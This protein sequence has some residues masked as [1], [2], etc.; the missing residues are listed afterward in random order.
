MPLTW[1]F[2]SRVESLLVREGARWR[3]LQEEELAPGLAFS[4][5]RAKPLKDGALELRCE[6]GEPELP[7]RPLKIHCAAPTLDASSPRHH[8]AGAL[9]W[10]RPLLELRGKG[11]PSPKELSWRPLKL[12]LSF[13]DGA[14]A[15][16]MEFVSSGGG[17][18]S[19]RG[20]WKEAEG[21]KILSLALSSKPFPDF[22]RIDVA[23]KPSGEGR[24]HLGYVDGSEWS[25][26]LEAPGSI[27]TLAPPEGD[28]EEAT[29][30]ARLVLEKALGLGEDALGGPC[31]VLKCYILSD[32][33][34]ASSPMSRS[35][36]GANERRPL[37][38][39]GLLESVCEPFG[40]PVEVKTVRK[41]KSRPAS[42][43]A[44]S[45][46]SQIDVVIPFA[47]NPSEAS[48]EELR[49]V[50]RSIERNFPALGQVWVATDAELTAF[51]GLSIVRHD[52]DPKAMKDANIVAKLRAVCENRALSESFI[53]WSDD[54]ILL[55]EISR[56]ELRPIHL[57]MID[58]RIAY[59]PQW[60]AMLEATNAFLASRGKIPLN[61]DSHAPQPMEKAKLLE[62]AA[63]VDFAAPPGLT[64]CSTYFGLLGFKEQDSL[65]SSLLRF[66][67][68]REAEGMDFEKALEGKLWLGYDEEAAPFV[69]PFLRRLFPEPS[70]WE[71]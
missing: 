23:R 4:A 12:S 21:F 24:L 6:A 26:K 11:I 58:P 20:L 53:F 50:L 36:K 29:A 19:S 37:S 66:V 69:L 44:Q 25:G 9:P 63:S 71:K 60:A 33:A 45:P 46:D 5:P 56:D 8:E 13:E 54:Q 34:F 49:Y 43:R 28:E 70:G 17:R 41:A 15:A 52:D 14:F 18:P 48:I 1:T 2:R 64:V 68:G 67:Q 3:P 32:D 51:E 65:P 42:A 40:I 16:K 7:G 10:L 59:D 57:G 27:G 22:T 39:A 62:M 38:F 35:G 47:S 30:L 61:W 31:D 55:R